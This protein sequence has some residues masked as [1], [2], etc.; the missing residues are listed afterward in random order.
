[1]VVNVSDEKAE[2]LA[3]FSPVDE[4]SAEDKPAGSRRRAS[5]RAAE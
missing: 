4:K 2:R 5:N 1:V 3:G